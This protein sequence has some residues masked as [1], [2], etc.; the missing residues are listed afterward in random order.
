M[1]FPIVYWLTEYAFQTVVLFALVWI[2]VKLQKLDQNFEFH[3]L[4]L[5]GV[6]ALASALNLIPY[7]GR[8]LS[9]SALLLGIKNVTRSPYIDVLFTVV[10]SYA[11]MFVV[12]LFIIGSLIGG[13]R[14]SA[15]DVEN[16]GRAGYPPPA[17]TIP[18]EPETVAQTNPPDT[19]AASVA[20]SNPAPQISVKPAPADASHFAVKGITRN[21][22]KSVVIINTGT[23]TY[24]LFLGDSINMQTAAGTS[25]VQFDNLDEDWV[26]LNVDGK[27]LKLPA[28]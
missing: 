11:L 7:F 28:H 12:N 25:R 2:M 26:T 10:I 13:L 9:V 23:K 1:N 15:G 4:K 18:K 22:A 17:Q 3:F 27:P 14:S 24:S 21:G 19:A 8:Y 6:V 16:P 5:L 20:P